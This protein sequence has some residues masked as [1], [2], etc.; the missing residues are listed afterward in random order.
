MELHQLE[1]ALAV[2]K[3]GGFTR[4]A[5]EINTS[6]S[7]LSQQISKLEHELGVNLF[8]RSTRSVQ[9]TP[10]GK[11]FL[12]YAERILADV[13]AARHCIDEYVS[14]GRGPLSLGIM[15]A[16]GYYNIPN[17]LSTFQKRYPEVS[18]S[19]R[20]DQCCE[21]LHLLHTTKIDAALIQYHGS[22]AN[23]QFRDV[24]ADYMVVVVSKQHPFALRESIDLLEMQNE[25]F[26][27]PPPNSGHYHHFY[28]VCLEMGF[29][30]KISLTCSSVRSIMGLVRENLGI[31]VLSSCVARLDLSPD[32]TI[33][34]LTPTITRNIVLALPQNI[35]M[36]P[37][38]KA[39]ANYT[40]Q[41][42]DCHQGSQPLSLK[43]AAT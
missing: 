33:I 16:V 6:Q 31:T 24:L 43:F 2:A 9:T 14:E 26:I 13:T 27:I 1:Y 8:I 19:L 18:L 35:D 3:H 28:S 15:P 21:L 20:E 17:L 25:H 11:K 29:V 7:A 40:A 41:W 38:L 36:S 37:P 12:A 32:L 23:F 39:F 4:A 5:E 10:I 34:P 30:P 42:V 22:N